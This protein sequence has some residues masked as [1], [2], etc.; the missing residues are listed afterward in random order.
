MKRG[1]SIAVFFLAI[2]TAFIT[3][4]SAFAQVQY[5]PDTDSRVWIEGRS[6]VNQFT[7]ESLRYEGEATL[8]E[9][10]IDEVEALRVRDE[11]ASIRIEIDVFD[12]ECGRG[13]MNRDLRD[14][15]R[16]EK[17]PK[18]TFIFGN[19]VDM[20]PAGQDENNSSPLSM[21]LEVNGLLTVAGTTRDIHVE[22]VG[23]F[24]D[25]GRLRA[26]GSKKILMTDFN[27]EPPVA[28]MG[29]VRAE[30]ELTV[31]FD[32]IAKRES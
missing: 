2:T 25:D 20:S 4:G 15:L 30:D 32:L 12:L 16:A 28:L 6:N 14:A 26:V 9:D 18:I 5:V 17:H 10:A 8:F 3:G 1:S 23:Y 11:Y 29:L 13:R 27:V 7:C 22:L 19:V 21:Q 24:L 31:H